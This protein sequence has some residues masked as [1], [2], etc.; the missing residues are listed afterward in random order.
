MS[1]LN[2]VSFFGNVVFYHDFYK[3]SK[4]KLLIS[5]AFWAN[6][7]NFLNIYIFME[8]HILHDYKSIIFYSL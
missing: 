3:I 1:L 7:A 5:L 8:Y 6:V 4:I 2:Y